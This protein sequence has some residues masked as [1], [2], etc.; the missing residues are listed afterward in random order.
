MTEAVKL[1]AQL[2][3]TDQGPVIQDAVAFL[4]AAKLFAVEGAEEYAKQMLMLLWSCE[5]TIKTAI[6]DAFMAMYLNTQSNVP[7]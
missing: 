4:T 7:G 1:V 5:P 6:A 3:H 2:L